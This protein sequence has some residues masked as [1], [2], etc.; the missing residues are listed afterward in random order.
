MLRLRLW[1]GLTQD[2]FAREAESLGWDGTIVAKIEAGT[3]S[4]KAGELIYLMETGLVWLSTPESD[5]QHGYAGIAG[6]HVFQA[7][8]NTAAER[9]VTDSERRAAGALGVGVPI[10]RARAL[11]AWGTRDFS[12]ERDRRLKE[13]SSQGRQAGRGAAGRISREMVEELRQMEEDTGQ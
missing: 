2:Q 13:R 6:F 9:K 4:L 5:K 3:R 10:L 11:R 12:A 1:A 8:R 7:Q